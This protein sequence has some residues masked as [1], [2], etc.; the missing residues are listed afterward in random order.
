MSKKPIISRVTELDPLIGNNVRGIRS[1][2]NISQEGLSELMG[3][4]QSLMNLLE[5][6]KKPW[7]STTMLSA[8]KALNIDIVELVGGVVL[9][10]EDMKDIQLIKELREARLMKEKLKASPEEK[11]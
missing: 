10:D 5:N 11:A 3:I 6:G 7:N 1:S 4:S 9:S 8:C 2:R